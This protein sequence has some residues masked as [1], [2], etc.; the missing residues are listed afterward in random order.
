MGI[1]VVALAA[2]FLGSVVH[3]WVRGNA[4]SLEV[5]RAKRYEVVNESGQVLSF[6]GPDTI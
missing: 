5:L 6:W 2:G 1:A 4:S 3:D